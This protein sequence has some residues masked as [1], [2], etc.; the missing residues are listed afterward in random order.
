[1]NRP[2][3]TNIERRSLKVPNWF[4]RLWAVAALLT[5]VVI[6]MFGTASAVRHV[7]IGGGD[8]FSKSQAN[9]ILWVADFPLHV[10][11][12]VVEV[13]EMASGEPLALLMDR[14]KIEK[15]HWIR[16]FPA[17]EDPGYLLMSGVVPAVKHSAVQLIRIS[18]GTIVSSWNPDW[19]AIFKQAGGSEKNVILGSPRSAMAV[20]PLLL[21]DG[22]IV[23]NTGTFLVRMNPC[24]GKPVWV[25]NEISHHSNELG[26]DGT[27]WVPSVSEDGFEGNPYLRKKVRDDAL[28]HISL[29]GRLLERLSF[30]RILRE[31]GLQAMALGTSGD[32]LN[33]DPIH[34]NEIQVA[35]RSSKYW[36]Q[37][38]LLISSSHLSTVFLYR[39]SSGQIV[40]WQTGPWMNQHSTNFVGDHQIS[41]FDD[42][43]IA[44]V[45]AEHA[46]L[47][48][49]DTNRVLLY[50][51][52]T[53]KVS[54][55]FAALLDEARP[56]TPTQGRA[57]ILPDGGLFVEETV[58]GR[59]LR[60]TQDGLLWSRVND[61][62]AQ[63]IGMVAWSRYL[64]ADEARGP[65]QAL[66]AKQCPLSG[67]TVIK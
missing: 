24:G 54:Q 20:H 52:V 14:K 27:L 45:A 44:G 15:S 19:E 3:P 48:P 11:E 32:R 37:G 49:T 23:F 53:K 67:Q 41:V 22:D 29:D 40:W 61:Y 31:N 39:P 60:F 4:F 59:H 47:S 56:I 38:D 5:L 55:P 42:N 7:T 2:E 64:T 18:D 33:V 21:A 10:R 50:D 28:A 26:P 51:F 43:V 9:I 1:M 35:S 17:A 65:L 16:R 12:A 8:R 36:Q 57:E 6:V 66:A 58:Y 63:R 30:I 62:D 13:S 25:L 34:I 46:F